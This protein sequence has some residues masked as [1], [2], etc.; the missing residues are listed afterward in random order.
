[1]GPDIRDGDEAE[2]GDR[3]SGFG[4]Y[5]TINLAECIQVGGW[6]RG[7]GGLTW[8][9]LR[10]RFMQF[11]AGACRLTWRFMLLN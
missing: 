3:P 4:D 11:Y 10:I 9:R 2:G 5:I 1:M 6:V 8:V 7:S